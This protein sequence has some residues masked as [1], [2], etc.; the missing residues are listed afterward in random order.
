MACAWSRPPPAGIHGTPAFPLRADLCQSPPPPPCF[1]W[2]T[3]DTPTPRLRLMG[4]RSPCGEQP[5]THETPVLGLLGS[6]RRRVCKGAVGRELGIWQQARHLVG[7]HLCVYWGVVSPTSGQHLLGGLRDPH[8]GCSRWGKQCS[9][10]LCPKPLRTLS[11]GNPH[12]H[13]HRG[14]GLLW[15]EEGLEAG[16][17]CLSSRHTLPVSPH[18]IFTSSTGER[19]SRV[20]EA[21]QLLT[22][23]WSWGWSHGVSREHLEPSDHA[24]SQ[25]GARPC[26]G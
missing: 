19:G 16:G 12:S 8:S 11:P 21:W 5:P 13:S 14:A 22:M 9:H 24:I 17:T 3:S 7:G 25:G 6:R 2:T 1:L 10:A 23:Q 26:S 15:W 20:R 4:L 18:G